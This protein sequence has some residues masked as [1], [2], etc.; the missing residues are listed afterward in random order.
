MDVIIERNDGSRRVGIDFSNYTSMTKQQFKDECDVNKIV[1]KAQ[2]NGT[3]DLLI[4]GNRE[5]ADVSSVL[6]YHA[7]Y[8]V[9]L[10]AQEQFDALSAHV[11]KRFDNDPAKFLQFCE[12]PKN[13]REMASLGLATLVEVPP[14]TSVSKPAKDDSSAVKSESAKGEQQ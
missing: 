4:S 8:N 7:A 13:A 12:D 5:Y 2:Q 11:R 14:S 6:D 10:K 1:P 9:V 3:L